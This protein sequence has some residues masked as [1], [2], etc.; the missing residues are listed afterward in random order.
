MM[1]GQKHFCTKETGQVSYL[2]CSLYFVCTEIREKIGKNCPITAVLW[3]M[4]SLSCIHR[5]KWSSAPTFSECCSCVLVFFRRTNCWS[6]HLCWVNKSYL[7]LTAPFLYGVNILFPFFYL[8]VCF[9]VIWQALPWRVLKRPFYLVVFVFLTTISFSEYFRVRPIMF[10]IG[11]PRLVP[12]QIN[13]FH[14]HPVTFHYTTNFIRWCWQS[15][16]VKVRS[17]LGSVLNALVLCSKVTPTNF[18]IQ[19]L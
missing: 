2:F 8:R 15:A 13:Y 9:C 12:Q 3:G 16:A 7:Q 5:L 10:P 19:T 11:V 14:F 1:L 18:V 17:E 6:L 4:L